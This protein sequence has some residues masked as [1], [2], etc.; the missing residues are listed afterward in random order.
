[1]PKAASKAASG[2]YSNPY[3]PKQAASFQQ[4]TPPV[5]F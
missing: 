4:K 5:S 2:K 3:L 1:M